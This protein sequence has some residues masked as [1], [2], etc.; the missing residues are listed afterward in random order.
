MGQTSRPIKTRITEHKSVIR[1]F[2]KNPEKIQDKKAKETSLARH[3]ATTKHTVAD[4]KWRVID[5]IENYNS[6]KELSSKLL[7][8]EVYCIHTLQTLQP[9]GLNEECLYTYA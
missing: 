1:S 9:K 3:F 5:S 6:E 2:I 7:K 8:R 4:L